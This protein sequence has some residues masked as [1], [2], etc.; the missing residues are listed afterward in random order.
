MKAIR[1]AG[2]RPTVGIHALL[3]EAQRLAEL[4]E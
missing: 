4:I 1:D 2:C 3:A